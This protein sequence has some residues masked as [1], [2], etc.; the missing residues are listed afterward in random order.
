MRPQASI[1][2]YWQ[3]SQSMLKSKPPHRPNSRLGEK[4]TVVQP[5]GQ[6]P[7]SAADLPAC[8]HSISVSLPRDFEHPIA[9]ETAVSRPAAYRCWWIRSVASTILSDRSR[10]SS[11][12]LCTLPTVG[13]AVRMSDRDIRGDSAQ[14]RKCFTTYRASRSAL[15]ALRSVIICSRSFLQG[16]R[17]HHR[18]VSR[19]TLSNHK[20]VCKGRTS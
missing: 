4:R 17:N 15:M 11:V 1:P 7:L 19:R 13:M 2:R 18:K 20:R 10:P 9:F 5:R 12:R 6:A 8:P 3:R 14:R 16:T